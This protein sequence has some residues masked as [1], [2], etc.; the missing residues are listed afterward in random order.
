MDLLKKQCLLR[1]VMTEEDWTKNYQDLRIIF[2]KD[3]YFTDLKENEVLREKVDMLNT[4]ATYNGMFFSTNYIR[5]NILK[6]TDDEMVKMDQEIEVDR[7]KQIQ[8]Q[9][10][11]QQLGLLNPEEQQ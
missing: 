2:S 4:L 5:K 8:Q 7:Q 9:L 11:M 1:G 10:Q 6:Q 3:S